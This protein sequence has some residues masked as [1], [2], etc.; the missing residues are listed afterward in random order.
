MRQCPHPYCRAR[1]PDGAEACARCG[2]PDDPR[3][4]RSPERF[5]AAMAEL[6]DLPE[7]ILD[8]HAILPRY[9]GIDAIQLLAMERV[10]VAR[11]LIQSAP[12]AAPSLL[13]N[14]EI[15]RIVAEHPDRLWGSWFVDPVRDGVAGLDR[16]VGAGCRVVKLLPVTGWRADDDELRPFWAAMA[17]RRLVAM[18]HTGFF[19]ARHKAEEAA[20]G[21]F[22]RSALGDPLHFDAPCRQFPD[23]V[24]ILCHAGG[25]VHAEA[26]AEMVSQ[27][28]NVWA[29]ISASGVFALSRILRGA[30]VDWSKLFWGNDGP[31]F[32]YPLNLRLLR[33]ALDEAGARDLEAALLRDNARRFAA[34][35]LRGG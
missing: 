26:A 1:W 6:P 24:V 5:A 7:G 31:P 34:S 25:S 29:D 4:L 32:A 10:G 19:T 8:L 28:D 22:A 14:A 23:L 11:A 13:G 33:A 18:V 17:E 27:H 35:H 21:V 15:A 3:L 12:D 30:A 9:P 2:H 20:A 16:A